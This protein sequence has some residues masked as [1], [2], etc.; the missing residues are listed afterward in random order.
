MK[1]GGKKQIRSFILGE[2]VECQWD[3]KRRWYPGT[4][5]KVGGGEGAGARY[6]VSYDDLDFEAG[7]EPGRIRP[8]P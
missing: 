7:V 8:K 1:A 5:V 6:D 3:N 4:I 2:K